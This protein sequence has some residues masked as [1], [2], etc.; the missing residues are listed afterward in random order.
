MA[1]QVDAPASLGARSAASVPEITP[2]PACDLDPSGPPAPGDP[3]AAAP[4]P[5]AGTPRTVLHLPSFR[6]LVRHALPALVESTI[7][8]AVLFY[9]VLSLTGFR[10][11]LVAALAWAYASFARRLIRRERVSGLLLLA[12]VVLTLRTAVSFATGSAFL[13]FVQP[14]AG[15]F[16]V[17][18]VFVVTA[19]LGKPIVERLARDFCPLDPELLASSHVRRFFQRVSLLWAAVLLTNVA[20]GLYFLLQSSLRTFVIERTVLSAG[21]EGLGVACSVLWFVRIM[22]RAGVTVR[23]SRPRLEALP[24]AS[25]SSGGADPAD[26]VD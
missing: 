11:A 4:D 3:A 26:P 17:A 21:L 18:L 14:S 7:G 1:L 19:L 13:Y 25:S 2:P 16:G 5:A 9:L 23:F 6:A 10:G 20:F 15:T 8:P 12:V 24:V 22:R